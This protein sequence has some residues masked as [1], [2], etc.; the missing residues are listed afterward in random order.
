MELKE[1]N[2]LIKKHTHTKEVLPEI[3]NINLKE[4]HEIFINNIDLISEVKE[5]SIIQKPKREIEIQMYDKFGDNLFNIELK[6][7]DSMEVYMELINGN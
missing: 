6:E 3:I 1:F 4:S 7:I 2:K 5:I